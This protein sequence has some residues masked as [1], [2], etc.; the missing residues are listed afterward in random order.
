MAVHKQTPDEIASNPGQVIHVSPN[1]MVSCSSTLLNSP[2]TGSQ[3]VRK[4][5]EE[6]SP[7]W[8]NGNGSQNGKEYGD[9]EMESV[10]TARIAAELKRSAEEEVGKRVVE[11]L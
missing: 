10:E 5:M 3:Q 1:S 7:S 8:G 9:D 4:E 11:I 6:W 2:T